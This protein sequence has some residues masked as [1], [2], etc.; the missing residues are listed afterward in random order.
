ML[1]LG[2]F[3]NFTWKKGHARIHQIKDSIIEFS[4]LKKGFGGVQK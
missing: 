4:N 3:G 1:F 2:K